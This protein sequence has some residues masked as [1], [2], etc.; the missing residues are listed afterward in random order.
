MTL[1]CPASSKKIYTSFSINEKENVPSN[2]LST[3][4]KIQSKEWSQ[5]KAKGFKEKE[6]KRKKA[7]IKSDLPKKKCCKRLLPQIKGQ[8]TLNF[9][10]RK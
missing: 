5:S 9:F 10:I 4:D 7:V 3:D 8:T 6:T 1:I 2:F